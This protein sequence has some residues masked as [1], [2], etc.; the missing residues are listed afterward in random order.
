MKYA[1]NTNAELEMGVDGMWVI[2]DEFTI[3]VDYG[4]KEY[5]AEF[6]VSLTIYHCGEWPSVCLMLSTPPACS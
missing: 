3:L 2:V 5:S 1:G 6:E 4:F